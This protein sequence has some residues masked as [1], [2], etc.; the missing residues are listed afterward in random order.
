MEPGTISAPRTEYGRSKLNGEQIIQ[1]ESVR[2]GF[3]YSILR[4][5]IVYGAG[6]RP[7]GMFGFFHDELPRHTLGSRL[8]W[9]GRI[10]VVEVSDLAY[11]LAEAA[12]RD[13]MRGRTFFVSSSEDPSMAELAE[14]AANCLGV[15]YQPLPIGKPLFR[16]AGGLGRVLSSISFLPHAARILGWRVSLVVD[17][18]SCDGSELTQLL[19]MKYVPWKAFIRQMYESPASYAE[20]TLDSTKQAEKVAS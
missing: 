13:E 17:G 5:P 16:L 12:V 10:S 19:E 1:A 7:G 4:L 20:S 9:P 6:Y 14:E 2:L 11:I 15:D 18:F 8:P 3:T